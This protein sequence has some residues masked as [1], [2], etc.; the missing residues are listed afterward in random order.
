MK[1]FMNSKHHL[2]YPKGELDGGVFIPPFEKPERVQMILDA[3]S[4]QGFSAPI[5][6][7]EIDLDFVKSIHSPDYVAF[8]QS[9]YSDWIAAGLQGEVMA[10]IFP[11]RSTHLDRPPKDIVGRTGYYALAVE[12]SIT[13]TTWSAVLGSA[14]AALDATNSAIAGERAAF[15]LCRPPG[16]HA[17]ADQFG[18]YCFLNNAALAAEQFLQSGAKRVA[19]LDVDFHHGNGTQSIFYRRDD[20]F[21]CSLHGHPEDEFPYY[22]GYADETGAG[23]GEGDNLNIRIRPGTVYQTWANGLLHAAK[24]LTKFATEA[25]F[26]SLGFDTYKNDPISSFK[27]ESDDFFNIGAK[28]AALNIP[29][30]FVMEGG[31]AVAEIGTNTV[32]TLTGFL[33]A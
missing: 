28:I 22:L 32:N 16:H 4:D 11:S 29:T 2:H 6:A 31:Y 18:G 15:A 3:L 19:V 25:L 21:F 12:T 8:L 5:E 24:H 20:V 33:N 30:V 13:E 23:A 26:V 14:A 10:N 9:A 7:G 1:T 17:T 27:L